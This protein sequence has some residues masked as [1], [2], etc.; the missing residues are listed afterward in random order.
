MGPYIRYTPEDSSK[1]STSSDKPV[2]A[3]VPAKAPK[4]HTGFTQNLR[5][6]YSDTDQEGE[7]GFEAVVA[8]HETD[9]V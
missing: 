7:Y 5:S 3:R 1:N 9:E 4:V 6:Q 8:R 2:V